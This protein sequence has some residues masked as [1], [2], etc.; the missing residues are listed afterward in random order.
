MILWDFTNLEFLVLFIILTV[1]IIS[2]VGL[3][4]SF[5][6]SKAEIATSQQSIK[7]ESNAVR[8]YIVDFKNNS[9]VYFS[10]SSIGKKRK[11][12]LSRFY[13]LFTPA[14]ADKLKAW[15]YSICVENRIVDDYLEVD[16]VGSHGKVNYFSV[17]KKIKYNQADGLLHLECRVMRYIAPKSTEP[18]KVKNGKAKGYVT[19][20]MM[21][22]IIQNQKGLTGYAFCVRFFYKNL[23]VNGEDNV[24]K[25]TVATLKNVVYRFANV[26]NLFRQIVDE[27]GNEIFL[28]DLNIAN[29][30]KASDLVANIVHEIK[31]VIAINGYGETISFA[32][33]VIEVSQYYQDFSAMSRACQQACIYAQQHNLNFYF[34]TR[35][36]KLII[37]ETGKYSQEITRLING[38]NLRY[39]YRPILNANNGETS[40]YFASIRAVESPFND[41]MEMSK[42]SAKVSR[43]KEFFAYVSKNVVSIFLSERRSINSKLFILCSINDVAFL[44]EVISQIPDINACKLVLLFLE[45]D[46]DTEDVD[47][48]S[49]RIAFDALKKDHV[50]IALS[51]SEKTLLLDP[52]IY[53]YFDYFIVGGQMVKEIRKNRFNRLSIHTLA[54]QLLKYK[55]PI[56]A[57]D[58]EG[59]QSIELIVKSGITLISS[60]TIAPTSSM[61]QALDRKKIKKLVDIAGN[62]R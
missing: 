58:L 7:K 22:D 2:I 9:V 17:I 46:F 59:W 54:E 34:Y 3:V 37:T 56:I 40:G 12:P 36:S 55:K 62:Y 26:D 5:I 31:K 41:Y 30:D 16:M 19:K 42:Y 60:E 52:L 35:S 50:E 33:G 21:K 45:T 15:L 14:D 18:K 51:I 49:I 32:V 44:D 25:V 29:R 6:F 23:Q 10:R 11:F 8:V 1:T 38:N 27:P 39:F 13:M 20:A 47:T 48:N 61:I 4:A 28:F 24:E 57:N 43:N 53:S